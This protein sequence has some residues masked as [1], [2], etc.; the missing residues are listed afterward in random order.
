[1]KLI[2]LLSTTLLGLVVAITIVMI[3]KR[4]LDDSKNNYFY[5]RLKNLELE[6]NTLIITADFS[7]YV[8]MESKLLNILSLIK[9]RENFDL[10]KIR[11]VKTRVRD[12]YT[13]E[14]INRAIQYYEEYN[15][16]KNK[17]IIA[18]I[19]EALAIQ[20][21]IIRYRFPIRVFFNRLFFMVKSRILFFV[22]G[23]IDNVVKI[24][25]TRKINKYENAEEVIEEYKNDKDNFPPFDGIDLC[26][27]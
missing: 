22:V 10:R 19:D 14:N 8:Q 16:C 27:Y 24:F 15:N 2:M 1:M 13:K 12:A 17:D 3:S 11:L 6:Y 4:K 20:E 26:T 25:D 7:E 21:E 23:I 5:L 9:S 18:L